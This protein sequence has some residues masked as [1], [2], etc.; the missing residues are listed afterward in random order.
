MEKGRRKEKDQIHLCLCTFCTAA[1]VLSRGSLTIWLI[2]FDFLSNSEWER[3]EKTHSSIFLCMPAQYWP[4]LVQSTGIPWWQEWNC[5][6]LVLRSSL[7]TND[8][9]AF[10][11]QLV[12]IIGLLVWYS[13]CKDNPFLIIPSGNR[14]HSIFYCIL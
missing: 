11:R 4:V 3:A 7:H 13:E 5:S 2:W 9:T 1:H 12:L 14:P 6:H 8:R 10:R